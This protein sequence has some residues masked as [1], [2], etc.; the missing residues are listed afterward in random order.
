MFAIYDF[1]WGHS[2]SYLEVH[3]SHD[4]WPAGWT[5]CGVHHLLSFWPTLFVPL[6]KLS[7]H[8]VSVS[9]SVNTWL[10]GDCDGYFVIYMKSCLPNVTN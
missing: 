9:V 10:F 7:V 6:L 3:L 1:L 8:E 2:H 4:L 5:P